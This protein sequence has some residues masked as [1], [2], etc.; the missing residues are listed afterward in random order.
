MIRRYRLVL[1]V[2][3]QNAG[4][5]VTVDVGSYRTVERALRAAERIL[6]GWPSRLRAGGKQR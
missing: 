6:T 1:N 3:R 5:W 4:H 2:P